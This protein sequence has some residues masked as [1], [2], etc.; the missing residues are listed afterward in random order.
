MTWRARL[1][2]SAPF[3]ARIRKLP[4]K[5]PLHFSEVAKR[6]G[7]KAHAE[8]SGCYVSLRSGLAL[9]GALSADSV[10]ANFA[11]YM[12]SAGI[13]TSGLSILLGI[14]IPTMLK[15]IHQGGPTL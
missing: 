9:A 2:F 11:G 3:K 1:R 4:K 10:L 14:M 7:R 15:N 12:S 13:I 8:R 5:R 6:N